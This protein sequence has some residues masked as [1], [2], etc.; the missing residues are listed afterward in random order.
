MDDFV[1]KG[2]CEKLHKYDEKEHEQFRED[3][4]ALANSVNELAKV[5]N[6]KLDK[7][8]SRIDDVHERV[9][10]LTT[11]TNAKFQALSNKTIIILIGI[12]FTLLSVPATL[13]WN[14][15]I[16]QTKAGIDKASYSSLEQK[17]AVISDQITKSGKV[18]EENQ[19]S[20]NSIKKKYGIK[21]DE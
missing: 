9:N 13:I 19:R 7:V 11:D 16:A 2:T 12:V 3:I 1:D 8:H 4:M 14:H 20:L 15:T 17:M 5:T 18:S 21:I 10:Q 6:G